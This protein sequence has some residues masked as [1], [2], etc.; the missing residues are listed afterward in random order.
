MH[1]IFPS[2]ETRS[3]SIPGVEERAT[4]PDSERKTLAMM[5]ICQ[6]YHRETWTHAYIDGSDTEATRDGGAGV[7]IRYRDGEE[8]LALPAGKFS[9]NFRAETEAL[10]AAATAISQYAARTADQVVLLSEGLS[11]LQTLKSSRNRESSALTTALGALS[12]AVKKV[13]VQWIYQHINCDTQGNEVADR[14][15]KQGR[16]KEQT[17]TLVSYGEAKNHH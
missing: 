10:H 5:L 8:K 16:G 7:F 15:A 12:H 6:N 9:T 1:F 11:V 17:D 3:T 13:T 4:Q 14:L 2:I